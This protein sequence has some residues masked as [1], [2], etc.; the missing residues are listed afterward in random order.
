MS[1]IV[2]F[3]ENRQGCVSSNC[4]LNRKIQENQN[5]KFDHAVKKTVSCPKHKNK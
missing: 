1:L 3:V 2:K 4:F 5:K